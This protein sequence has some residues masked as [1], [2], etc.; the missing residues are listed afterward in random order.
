MAK[1]LIIEQTRSKIGR[2]KPQHEALKG[3]GLRR[4]GHRV[5]RDDSPRVRGQINVISHLV[6]VEEAGS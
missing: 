6:K 1:K 3:L 4:I 2:P 5:E